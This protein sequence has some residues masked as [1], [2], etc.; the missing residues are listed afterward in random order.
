MPLPTADTQ[1]PPVAFKQA[2]EQYPVWDAWYTGDEDSLE[3]L[4]AITRLQTKTSIWGQVKR[5]FW[6][7]P[8]AQTVSQRPVKI[9]VPIAA[10]ISRMSSQILFGQMPTIGFAL[11]DADDPAKTVVAQGSAQAAKP[12]KPSKP[13]PTLESVATERLNEILDDN[14]HSVL[15]EAAEYASAHGGVFLKATWDQ[16]VD[17]DKPFID[18]VAADSAVPTFRWGRLQSVVFWTDLQPLQGVSASWKLL[19]SHDVGRV[20]WGLFQGSSVTELGI[21]VPLT[22]H[23]ATAFLADIVDANAGVDTGSELLTAVYV[24][25]IAPNGTWRKFPMLSSLGRSDYDGCEDLFDDYDEM[26]TSLQ[27]EFRLGK[28][29]AVVSKNLMNTGTPGQAAVFNAD[30]EF[31]VNL[32]DTPA[33]SMPQAASASMSDQ[34]EFIQPQL[35]SEQ[36]L[37][38]LAY[39]ASRIYQ[40]AGFS[41]QTF[42]DAGE[43]AVTATEV[44]ARE[45]LTA[46]T[47]QAKILYWRPQLSRLFAALMDVDQFVFNGPGRNNLFPDIEWTD[48][49]AQDPLV[50]A[51]TLSALNTSESASIWTRVQMLHEDWEDDQIAEEVAR[52]RE[53]YS[54]LPDPTQQALWAAQSE[55]GS[56]SGGVAFTSAGGVV[57]SDQPGVAPAVAPDQTASGAEKPAPAFPAK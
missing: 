1:W 19:E 2:F 36:H 15:L 4:Y 14:A 55:T 30:Q 49:A 44:T 47:R 27:R 41:P 9:H 28:A 8:T 25:N 33:G 43:V 50:L 16:D 31:F 52:I 35:R 54:M 12:S 20:E 24:P 23:P 11:P 26:H 6:G 42:G 29:R 48:A 32:G 56:T 13:T 40:A 3:Y 51:Q 39:L 34:I 10:D 7:T 5:R 45:K 22:E 38:V 53:D 17:P 37:A 18:A 57:G 21:S 46:L